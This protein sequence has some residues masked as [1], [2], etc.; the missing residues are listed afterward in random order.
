[1]KVV[2]MPS[3]QPPP[4]PQH[5]RPQMQRFWATVTKRFILEDHHFCC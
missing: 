3:D 1:M 4:P 2:Q 5:L